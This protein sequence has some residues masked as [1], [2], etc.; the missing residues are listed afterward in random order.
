[1]SIRASSISNAGAKT[2]G[3]YDY[4]TVAVGRVSVST[5]TEVWLNHVD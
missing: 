3:W 5:G 2:A 4:Q 1:M